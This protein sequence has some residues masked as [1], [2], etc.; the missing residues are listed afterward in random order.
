MFRN[1]CCASNT[2]QAMVQSDVPEVINSYLKDSSI[3]ID[4]N[5]CAHACILNQHS[6][7]RLKK[8]LL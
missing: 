7:L 5:S 3:G 8:L 4:C 1:G 2:L 6:T